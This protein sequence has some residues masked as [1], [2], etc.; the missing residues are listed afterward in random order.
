MTRLFRPV[1]IPYL[2]GS[3]IEEGSLLVLDPTGEVKLGYGTDAVKYG[4][5]TWTGVLSGGTLT[6]SGTEVTISAGTG[7]IVDSYTDPINPTYT[8]VSWAEQTLD[9]GAVT[10]RNRTNLYVDAA[11]VFTALIGPVSTTIWRTTIFVGYAYHNYAGAGE[12]LGTT[13]VHLTPKEVGNQLLDFIRATSVFPIL[14]SGTGIFQ[15][16]A[17]LT[18]GITEQNWWAPGINQD[19]SPIDPNFKSVDPIDPASIYYVMST[20][21]VVVDAPGGTPTTLVDPARYEDPLGTVIPVPGSANRATIQ[22]LYVTL[23]GNTIMMYGQQYYDNLEEARNALNSDNAS[24]ITPDVLEFATLIAYLVME[25]ASTDLQDGTD[26]IIINPDGVPIGGGATGAHTHDTRYMMWKGPW[27]D[28]Q[29]YLNDVVR[30]AEWLMIANKDTTDRPAPQP[31]GGEQWAYDG[32]S[33]T[34]S[35]TEKQLVY[36]QRYATTEPLFLNGYRYWGVLG[37]RYSVFVVNDPVGTPV[38][39]SLLSNIIADV[40]GW[41]EFGLPGDLEDT[42]V[43]D[44]VVVVAE[45]DPTPTTWS[46]N[47]NYITPNNNAIPGAGEIQHSSKLLTSFRINKTDD[48]AGDR[49]TELEALN[50]GDSIS[51]AGMNWAIQAITDNGTWMAFTVAPAQQGA[52]E[53]TQNFDF[54]TVTPTPITHVSDT[55][56]WTG[57]E[58]NGQVQGFIGTSYDNAI[59]SLNQNAYGVDILLQ[60]AAISPDWDPLAR[61]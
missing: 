54:E 13:Q 32:T 41:I 45:P 20:G 47:W 22:R 58:F 35:L 11:G 36:G 33:P 44:L 9:F 52:P 10:D 59:L 56:Y 2:L 4:E 26:V 57:S 12:I 3:P 16:N 27:V 38:R 53:G 25:K 43:F 61:S 8:E 7:V 30:D 21:A 40:D 15:P 51:G 37:N 5:P 46:G 17:D 19:A 55:N 31:I 24:H 14:V 29:Y 49:S 6:H 50:I 34:N 28:G 39:R 48:D 60:R 23:A 18:F 42:S 1:T